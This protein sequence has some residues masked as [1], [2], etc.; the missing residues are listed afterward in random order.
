MARSPS[1]ADDGAV[2]RMKRALAS[3]RDPSVESALRSTATTALVVVLA[4]ASTPSALPDTAPA[5]P[6]AAQKRGTTASEK[7]RMR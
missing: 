1:P 4:S 2:T 5:Q 7:G 3:A 6:R